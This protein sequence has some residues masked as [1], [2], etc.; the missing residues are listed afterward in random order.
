[1]GVGGGVRSSGFFSA[2][3]RGRRLVVLVYPLSV[4]LPQSVA[5]AGGVFFRG[6]F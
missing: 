3:G 2:R 4:V 1:M 6:G 5:R